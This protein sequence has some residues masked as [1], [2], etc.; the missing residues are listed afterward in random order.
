MKAKITV[1]KKEPPSLRGG[2][3]F[4]SWSG[5]PPAARSFAVVMRSP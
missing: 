2:S 1:E 5:Q 4:M 3:K